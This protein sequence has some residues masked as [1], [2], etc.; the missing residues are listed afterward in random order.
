[1]TIINSPYDHSAGH[2]ITYRYDIINYFITKYGYKNY[3]EIGVETGENI[4]RISVPNKTGIDPKP[5]TAMVTDVMTSDEFFA[6]NTRTFDI[7]FI[8][9][10]HLDHQVDKDIANSL[11][12]LQPKGTIVLH[13]CNP[14]TKEHGMDS[15]VFLQWNGTVW[16]SIVKQR[17]LNKDITLRVVNTD[18]GCGVLQKG[19]QTVYDKAPLE[20]CLDWDYFSAN[21][22][23]LLNLI[24][25]EEFKT[26]YS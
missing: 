3:L 5:Q 13:D 2:D 21:R 10:L 16:K 22:V 8:D 18:W 26:I 23:E 19:N 7:I 6:T 15:P 1:M 20:T 12:W 11:L 17:C 9:G 14:P 4:S 24:S 25:V